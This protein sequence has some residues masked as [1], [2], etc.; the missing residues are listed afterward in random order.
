MFINHI[1]TLLQ[2]M[3]C[4]TGSYIPLLKIRKSGKAINGAFINEGGL[5]HNMSS[6]AL[7]WEDEWTSCQNS[8]MIPVGDDA[9]DFIGSS[10]VLWPLFL[11]LCIS[12]FVETVSCALEG[13]QPMPETGMTIF[14]HS[15]AF[16]EAEAVVR[17]TIGPNLFG[18]STSGPAETP[19]PS[20]SSVAQQVGSQAVSVT[21]TMVLNRLNVP[22]EVLLIGLISSFSHLSSQVL[23]VLGLQSRFRLV[24]TGI[25]GMCF[26]S[27][28][29]WSFMRFSQ[30]LYMNDYG[31]LR[32]PTVCIIGFIPH[33]MIILG[34]VVCAFIYGL[35]IVVTMLSPP[36]Q[37][38]AQGSIIDRLRMAHNNLQAHVSLSNIKITWRDEFYTTI[39]KIGFT[40]L[41]A[42]CEAVYFNEGTNITVSTRTWLEDKRQAELYSARMRS[43]KLH[44]QVPPELQGDSTLVDG[45]G[46]ID[47]DQLLTSPEGKM[48]TTGFA[49]ER[50][51]KKNTNKVG[52]AATREEGVGGAT[53]SGRWYMSWRLLVDT[54]SLMG[55][56]G[57]RFIV[58]LF[59][60]VGLRA[61]VPR[62]FVERARLLN[63]SSG[64]DSRPAV[65]GVLEFW[66]LSDSGNLALPSNNE[67]DVEVETRRRL[68]QSDPQ[69]STESAI[70]SNLYGWFKSGG[71]WGEVDA[72]G[73]YEP[74]VADDDTTSVVSMSDMS[75][76][77]WES[78]DE[79]QRT[80]TQRRPGGWSR[81]GTAEPEDAF[82]HLA[83]LLDQRTLESKSEARLLAS[84][85]RSAGPLTRSRYN[86]G[87]EKDQMRLLHPNAAQLSP[88]EEEDILEQIILSRRANAPRQMAS[89]AGGASWTQ[90]AEGLGAE[91]PQCVVCHSS[92]RTILVWPCR[93]LSLCDECRVS[94]AMNNFGSCVCCRRD[95]V[96]F[97]KLYVP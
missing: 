56:C 9:M 49:R 21:R 4:Q 51:A 91:G 15:L 12:H 96:A 97:S 24:N 43:R 59:R 17:S 64:T 20:T 69:N 3:R 38:L 75:T 87:V 46:L 94:L 18:T 42:A 23:G 88:E 81:E 71:W 35:A 29:V 53:R 76:S 90:G 47:E 19:S 55:C 92:P 79:G 30:S 66:M 41:T 45:V 10:A 27:A 11:S 31:E 39:L 68:R 57:A 73:D 89:S 2:T 28:F 74:S 44:V 13:R 60:V 85:L 52:T 67:V 40:V 70:D 54:S 80:P 61:W 25:W 34:T 22:S 50:K 36:S 78:E 58:T 48:L 93:C 7:F 72:S 37:R 5:L 77:E 1:V 84:H 8:G 16:A 26:I 65:P 63:E 83:E 14:E 33:L 32:Y 6:A 86:K 95:V 82:A 62:W